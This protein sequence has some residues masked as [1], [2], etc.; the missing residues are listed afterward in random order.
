M[1][2]PDLPVIVVGLGFGDEGKGAVVDGLTR[3]RGA[4]L[5]VRF[6]GGPQAA[7][8]VVLPTGEVHC[9]AQFG[10][11]TLAGAETYLSQFMLVNPLN[12]VREA[13]KLE[14]FVS[15]PLRLLTINAHCPVVTPF[16]RLCN[17]ALEE[18]QG[19][20]S[21]G[22][23]V[24]QAWLDAADGRPTLSWGLLHNEE[25]T[26]RSLERI[27]E[28]KISQYPHL[29]IQL[30]DISVDNL[31]SEYKAIAA[32]IRTDQGEML[33]NALREHPSKVI[34]EGAQG[35]LLDAR[36][37][38][39]PYVTP[40]HTS[41]GNARRLLTMHGLEG[42]RL[43]VLRSYSTRHGAGPFVVEDSTMG[44][45]DEP[46]NPTGVWQKH[47]RTGPFDVVAARYGI[48]ISQPNAIFMTHVDRISQPNFPSRICTGWELPHNAERLFGDYEQDSRVLTFHDLVAVDL[49]TRSK[50]TEVMKNCSPR[51]EEINTSFNFM[52]RIQE[53]IERPFVGHSKGPTA[54]HHIW[55]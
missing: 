42:F 10:S 28:A 25:K 11:G 20:G 1:I 45:F 30:E 34:F 17:R 4:R 43:G 19:H 13:E 53:L 46:H 18:T 55:A 37:G 52:E 35:A 51:W 49:E 2:C 41:C 36:F 32:D 21:C 3:K 8:H 9:F 12:L 50:H 6:N 14:T 39:F 15:N 24:G 40:S 16:H 23:G 22:Q 47:M 29:K 54:Q 5:V 26:R 44:A 7:H 27:R 48:A 33:E 31:A 38:F